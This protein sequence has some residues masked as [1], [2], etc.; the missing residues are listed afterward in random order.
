MGR[1]RRVIDA[2]GGY[3]DDVWALEVQGR[4]RGSN[5]ER[6]A[7]VVVVGGRTQSLRAHKGLDPPGEHLDVEDG[8][9]EEDA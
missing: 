1:A 3:T 8:P 9:Q 7:S 4:V 6:D 2:R 5:A